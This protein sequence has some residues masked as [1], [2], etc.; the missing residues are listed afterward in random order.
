MSGSPSISRAAHAPPAAP[1]V[2]FYSFKGGVGR[3]VAL[4]NVAG[5]LAGRGFRVL[6]ID[7][8]LEGP[9]ISYLLR[10]Q[11]PGGAVRPGLVELLAGADL[12]R[13]P[14]E[15]IE[16][17]THAYALPPA[18]ID[19][20]DG[21]L[22]VLPVGRLDDGYRRRLGEL[23]LSGRRERMQALKR[24]IG[25]AGRFD[26]VLVDS[27]SGVS[28]ASEACTRALADRLV[29][30]S[31]LNRQHIAGTTDF[32]RALRQA[33]EHRP[34]LL[35]VLS[36]VPVGE[37]E[38]MAR[39]EQAA[40]EAW[41][42]AWQGPVELGGRIFFH[43]RLLL[44]EE[45]LEFRG[46][47]GPL[48]DAYAALTLRIRA[49]IGLGDRSVYDEVCA[50]IRG[51]RFER[52]LERG[53]VLVKLGGARNLDK[54][55]WLNA[56]HFRGERRADFL[57]EFLIEHLPEDAHLDALGA[58][59]HDHPL[60]GRVYERALARAPGDAG[61]LGNLAFFRERV[62]RDFDG[63]ESLYRQAIAA[64]PLHAENLGFFAYFLQTIRKDRAGAEAYYRRSLAAEPGDAHNLCNLAQLLL[65]RGQ[66]DEGHEQLER[67]L[68]ELSADDLS[69]LCELHFYA[70][71][72]CGERWPEALGVLK[73]LLIAGVR[74]PGWDLQAN[75]Q[76]ARE[77]GHAEAELVAALAEVVADA[78]PLATLD[79]FAAWQRA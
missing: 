12:R 1:F 50:A 32:L 66:R 42:A 73:R 75:V 35:F 57:L 60:V 4:F 72:H 58:A 69:P 15:V 53:R 62:G 37:D 44:S 77:D 22:R 10:D 3:S 18:L 38:L 34:E 6:V 76:R 67:A 52:A 24:V 30:M 54:L 14:G 68:A 70:Y 9:G 17:Y 78:A 26:L 65:A 33:S 71:A 23:D 48:Q 40:Q 39:R 51:Q 20:P 28:A 7:F 46:S 59:I 2:T 47:R 8:D 49:S 21:E 29:V 31:G 11:S 55:I 5:M 45:P 25:E 64:E 43:P 41:T 19:D 13:D 16:E 74:S 27:G 36:P 61:A 56:E 63:A 79:G